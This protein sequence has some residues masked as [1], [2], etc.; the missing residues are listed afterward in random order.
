MLTVVHLEHLYETRALHLSEHAPTAEAQWN[1]TWEVALA[2]LG[3]GPGGV[4]PVSPVRLG[5][6]QKKR[7]AGKGL[8]LGLNHLCW[9]GRRCP[10]AFKT[11]IPPLLQ[12]LPRPSGKYIKCQHQHSHATYGFYDSPFASAIILSYDGGGNDGSFNIFLAHRHNN[13]VRQLSAK[14]WCM[15]CAIQRMSLLALNSSTG[16][17][18]Q[19]T[20]R[21][22]D[23]RCAYTA[24]ARSMAL[25]VLGNV[26]GAG[27][28][29]RDAAAGVMQAQDWASVLVGAD[30]SDAQWKSD[31]AATFYHLLAENTTGELRAYADHLRSVEGLVLSGGIALNVLANTLIRR[32]LGIRTHVALAPNDGGIPIGCCFAINPPSGPPQDI[33]YLGIPL[34][35]ADDEGAFAARFSAR[36]HTAALLADL[37]LEGKVL[38]VL[39]GRRGRLVGGGAGGGVRG[40][41]GVGAAG[42]LGCN[43]YCR[44]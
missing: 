5:P 22:L 23:P 14:H 27:T 40:L 19:Q 16:V 28:P 12:I 32:R 41:G 43:L 24:V 11:R 36:P 10:R 34:R 2:T 26:H 20:A 42:L 4:Q 8:T 38:G 15:A 37:L 18:C 17:D 9:G 6:E 31:F 44:Q 13:S 1:R 33:R 30:D 25:G 3:I 7:V 35:D 21:L 39:R 29:V